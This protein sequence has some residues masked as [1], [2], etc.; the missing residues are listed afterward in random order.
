MTS[1][2]QLLKQSISKDSSVYDSGIDARIINREL[3]WLDFNARVLSLAADSEIELLERCKFVAIFCSNLDE[4]YQI[5]VAAL[6]DQIAADVSAITPD[7]RTPRQQLHEIIRQVQLLVEQLETVYNEDLVPKLASNG[8]QVL[9]WN[10]VTDIER[11]YLMSMFETRI[12]P[13][14]TPL[15]VDPAHPFPYISNLALNLAVIALD[16]RTQEKRFARVKIPP[17]L[18]RFLQLPDSNRFVLLED[19]VSAN[20]GRL[21]QGMTIEQCHTFR[22]T[23]NADLSVDDEDA[24]DLLAA[25][26]M[27]LRRRRF[28]RAHFNEPPNERSLFAADEPMGALRRPEVLFALSLALER[29]LGQPLDGRGRRTHSA[30]PGRRHPAAGSWQLPLCR[31]APA[32]RE[33]DEMEAS[34][35]R[36]G[37]R[38]ARR[39]RL[40]RERA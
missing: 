24:E 12:F 5:R 20:L 32:A 9:G 16:P 10:E 2:R 36:P 27:E 17:T 6:K 34:D 19:V 15:A 8:V 7:G 21:F 33:L 22:V 11:E 25:V 4:F 31:A 1:W 30:L 29:S 35:D 28:G 13:V 26:E 39:G 3:S 23:R 37:S 38:H 40:R 18:P 14:L